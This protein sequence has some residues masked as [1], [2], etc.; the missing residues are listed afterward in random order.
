MFQKKKRWNIYDDE[1]IENVSQFCYL[2]RRVISD[3]GHKEEVIVKLIMKHGKVII[4][5]NFNHEL[6]SLIQMCEEYTLAYSQWNGHKHEPI[7]ET[8]GW[9]Y[10]VQYTAGAEG[11]NCITTDTIVFYSQN[12][13]YKIMHQSA[14]RIDRLNSPYTDLYYYHLKTRSGI[15]LAIAKALKYKK[16]FNESS[17]A[18]M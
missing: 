11:W 2:L 9:V 10:L 7:P 17:F 4:F 16:K 1:P 5:Y 15:D 3:G 8:N 14:G 12:Y 6:E 18:S 13:S